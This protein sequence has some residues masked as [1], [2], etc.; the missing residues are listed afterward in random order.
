MRCNATSSL[1]NSHP[2]FQP[3]HLSYHLLYQRVRRMKNG[4][5]K[6]RLKS[7]FVK[8][9]SSESVKKAKNKPRSRKSKQEQKLNSINNAPN[10][11]ESRKKVRFHSTSKRRESFNIKPERRTLKV[12]NQNGSVLDTNTTLA[13]DHNPLRLMQKYSVIRELY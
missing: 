9:K 13:C 10:C 8:K 4:E 2:P 1:A 7:Y 5:S 3:N 11:T 6:K 12:Q